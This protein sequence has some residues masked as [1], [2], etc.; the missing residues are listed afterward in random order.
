MGAG[1]GWGQ[2]SHGA[3]PACLTPSV[4]HP[5]ELALL[6]LTSLC[7]GLEQRCLQPAQMLQPQPTPSESDTTA[8]DITSAE[9]ST[10]TF[11]E[12]GKHQRVA[13]EMLYERMPVAL[14]HYLHRNVEAL[15]QR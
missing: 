9:E 4:L 12:P 3:W 15:Q 14:R 13:G 8:T 11:T 5:S 1:D 2:R 10:V 6:T 7:S